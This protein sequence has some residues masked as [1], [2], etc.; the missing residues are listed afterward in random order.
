MIGVAVFTS[1]FLAQGER[2]R[3]K[4]GA[5]ERASALVSALDTELMS[6][7]RVLKAMANSPILDSDDLRAFSAEAIQMFGANRIGSR[8]F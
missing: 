1:A 2:A 3:F 5:T 6:S 8:L 7:I 4:Q